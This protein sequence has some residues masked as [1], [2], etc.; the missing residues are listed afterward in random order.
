MA[1]ALTYTAKRQTG[2]GEIEDVGFLL[3][4]MPAM[5]AD[6]GPGGLLSHEA[7]VDLAYRIL[8]SQIGMVKALA[9]H[10]DV[11]ELLINEIQAALE[12]G[13]PANQAI[14]MIKVAGKWVRGESIP[15]AEFKAL[16]DHKLKGIRTVLAE[17]S[18]SRDGESDLFS[19]AL[20]GELTEKMGEVVPY[21]LIL[22]KAADHF[23]AR[24]QD[25]ETARR[26]LVGFIAAELKLPRPKVKAIIGEGWIAP[27]LFSTLNSSVYELSLYP[28]K[29]KKPFRDAVIDH[30]RAIRDLVIS[31]ASSTGD[32]AAAW[33]SFTSHDK[34]LK[35]S[36][37]L[38]FIRNRPLVETF[39][40]Q[41]RHIGDPDQLRSA[42][43]MGLLRVIY[44]FAPERGFRFST[45]GSQWIRQMVV[46]EL[47]QLDL[48]RLPEGSQ[49]NLFAIRAVLAERPNA[50]YAAI[51]EI[52]GLDVETVSALLYFVHGTQGGVSL[53]SAY[54][55][56]GSN[57][58]DGLHE[59]LADSNSQ[60]DDILEEL[61]STA[62][63][64]RVLQEVLPERHQ[65]VVRYQFGIGGPAL[66]L[67]DIGSQ[68]GISFERVRQIRDDA[69]R[70]LRA[71]KYFEDLVQLWV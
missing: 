39:V 60:I 12:S 21:D 18:N 29:A 5:P 62:F 45:L 6:P 31:G 16:A 9:A 71:S 23:R 65:Q 17:M 33:S 8:I 46:R 44:R 51:A 11:V 22:F 64:E 2:T 63:V 41:Y 40:K 67:K 50:S 58:V 55:N 37:Q 27:G 15:A 57:D 38:M 7:H 3:P 36:V 26:K 14:A 4:A 28:H 34:A 52:T 25:L 35:D 53:D 13:Q 1:I 30:Q 19:M 48:I 20:R 42:G 61:D 59:V 54:Q 10:V 47:Q 49:A 66:T 69:L 43:D 24:C 56:E 32:L 70:L 68:M